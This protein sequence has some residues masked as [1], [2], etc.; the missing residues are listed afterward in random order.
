MTNKLSKRKLRARGWP[1]AAIRE[2]LPEPTLKYGVKLPLEDRLLFDENIVL[3]KEHTEEFFHHLDAGID[4]NI[5]IIKGKVLFN[6]FKNVR[7]NF[8]GK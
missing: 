7:N 5:E 2:L 4:E 3:E 1:E 8:G 6:Y